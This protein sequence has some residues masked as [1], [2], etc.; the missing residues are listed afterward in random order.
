MKNQIEISTPRLFLKSITPS[1]IHE[2]FNSKSKEEIVTYFGFDEAGYEHLKKMHEEGMETHRLSLFYFLLVQKETNEP[3]GEC[4]FHTWNKS[5][6]RTELF[7][8]IKNDKDKQQGY[9]TEAL[10]AVLAFGFTTLNLHRVE[11]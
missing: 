1:F 4:G 6:R 7:Y 8:N 10:Q 2:F 11:A 5:H 3:I 9:M